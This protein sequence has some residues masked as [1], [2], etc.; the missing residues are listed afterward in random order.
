MNPEE[1]KELKLIAFDPEDLDIVSAH[2][3][4]AVISVGEMTF[5]KNDRRFAAIVSRFDWTQALSPSH[6][7][8]DPYFRRRTALRFEHVLGAQILGIDLSDKRRTLSILALTFDAVNAP[9]GF[10]TITCAGNASIKLQVECL[11]AELR[12]L[13]AAWATTRMPDHTKQKGKPTSD[14]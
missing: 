7:A 6:R 10:V 8:R 1:I 2:L 14:T 4:D 5:H 12:D 13:G 11:E 9:G 3:Q